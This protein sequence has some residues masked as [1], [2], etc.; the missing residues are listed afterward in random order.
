MARVLAR[1]PD[2]RELLIDAGSCA[3]HKDPAGLPD[4]TW[5]SFL[6]DPS[7]VLKRMTQEVRNSARESGK[8]WP[9]K[10]Q[11][12]FPFTPMSG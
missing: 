1:Y 11:V 10:T 6:H 7:L 12:A 9:A 8:L 3:L 4:G 5:G 2:R